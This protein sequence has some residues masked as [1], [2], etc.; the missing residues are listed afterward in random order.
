MKVF[1]GLPHPLQRLPSAVA[2]GNFDGV[3]TGHQELIRSVVH[4]AHLRGL[5]P[6]VVTFEP[7]PREK[8]GE[9]PL[10]RISTLCDKVHDLLELGIERIYVLPFHQALA[11]LTAA[12]FI[13]KILR[14]G[15]DVHWVTVG[16]DF[17]FG[18]DRRGNIDS[19]QAFG[20][21]MGFETFVAPL[22]YHYDQKVSSSRIRQAL[23]AGDLYEVGLMLGHHY[24]MSGRVIHGAALGRTL[25]FPT[26]NLA[27]IPP[28][29]H[30]TPAARGVY[31]VKVEGLGH[32]VRNGVASLGLKPTVAT[33]QRWLLEVNVFD[34][35]GNAYGHKVRVT[36]IEK[37]RDEQKFPSLD[38]LRAQIQN[39][40][41]IARRILG[42]L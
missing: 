18:S 19:L 27:P 28:G 35:A 34:W 22:V 9:A 10:P 13:Q 2:I 14:E 29:S 12:E 4:A 23:E 11:R 32:A 31:A 33:D 42:C 3:H 25:G 37:I 40:A 30:A 21:Q 5:V 8:L 7:H 1:R 20:Q 41:Q 24:T 36:F 26:L 15:L 16:E 6:S 38:A 17:H 39:D